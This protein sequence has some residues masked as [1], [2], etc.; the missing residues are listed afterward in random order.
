MSKEVMQ[1][2]SENQARRDNLEPEM[3]TLSFWDIVLILS[4]GV[5]NIPTAITHTIMKKTRRG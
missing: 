1:Q 2:P 5:L 4:R 3:D